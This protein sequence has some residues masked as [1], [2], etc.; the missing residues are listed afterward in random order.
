MDRI[1]SLT[2]EGS[3]SILSRLS[4]GRLRMESIF[5]SCFRA[6]VLAGTAGCV[7]CAGNGHSAGGRGGT[8]GA[9]A[10]QLDTTVA[11]IDGRT[12]T[13]RQLEAPLI[14]AHGL[15]LLMNLSQLEVVKKA[16]EDKQIV[17]SPADIDAE[18]QATLGKMFAD[19][20][21]DDYPQLLNQFL[22]QQRLTEADFNIL[23]ETNAY[24]RKLARPLVAGK[25]TDE[26]VAQA[27]AAWY[28][29]TVQVRHIQLANMQEVNEARRR[30]AA[31]ESFQDVATALSRNPRTAALG[32]EMPT[33]SRATTD[34]PQGFK[35]AA[36]A[37]KE[38]EVSDPVQAAGMYHLI[39]L[40]RRIAPRAVKLEDV[41][42]VV[43]QRLEEQLLQSE[44]N[45]LRVDISQHVVRTI[46]IADPVLA[47]QFQ[48]KT[49]ESDKSV[50]GQEGI[51]ERLKRER[52][53]ATRPATT[54]AEATMPAGEPPATAASSAPV[55][56]THPASQP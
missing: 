23:L 29:E 22:N 15:N 26:A 55:P 42:D 31:G 17:L 27:F 3:V 21:K 41:K 25:I 11:V 51:R 36:F 13:L 48:A 47:K 18:R 30:L 14:E 2:L 44:M 8:S 40:E 53:A 34:M 1:L 24:L 37:L 52:E 10:G 43:H 33:F 54:T 7:G 5:K 39:K 35:D 50:R 28:G 12:I 56:A 4:S 46:R 32:G 20:Q 9:I 16:A 6:L 38:G 19:A 49:E 45:A